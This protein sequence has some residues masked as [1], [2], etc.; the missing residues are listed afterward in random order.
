MSRTILQT[1]PGAHSALEGRALNA[2]TLYVQYGRQWCLAVFA[3][4]LCCFVL[5]RAAEKPPAG[6][7]SAQATTRAANNKAANGPLPCSALG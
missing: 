3:F 2:T 6:S 7:P 4:A 5:E 1:S